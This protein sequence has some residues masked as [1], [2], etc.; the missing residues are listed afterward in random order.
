MRC[1][2]VR[3]EVCCAHSV[4]L[5]LPCSDCSVWAP[6]F[7]PHAVL[8]SFS[9]SCRATILLRRQLLRRHSLYRHARLSSALLASCG[10]YRLEYVS[11][12]GF[13]FSSEGHVGHGAT[14]PRSASTHRVH[15]H[16]L[17]VFFPALRVPLFVQPFLRVLP[18]PYPHR[19]PHSA[20]ARHV[21]DEPQQKNCRRCR[22]HRQSARSGYNGHA[23]RVPP[24]LSLE[25]TCPSAFCWR[26]LANK[27][28]LEAPLDDSTT[29][30][31]AV[32]DA[33]GKDE[34]VPLDGMDTIR[35]VLEQYITCRALRGRLAPACL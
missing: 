16:V 32:K 5:H 10:C 19:R 11:L 9:V 3:D 14:Q 1:G 27:L 17:L 6:F 4:C 7:T 30:Q 8:L 33:W 20:A 18:H 15:Q 12:S 29:P 25:T 28:K 2:A 22:Q 21:G 31:L 23:Q 35:A 13:V 34:L 24:H 26:R